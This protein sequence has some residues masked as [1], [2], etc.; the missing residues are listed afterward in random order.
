MVSIGL[1]KDANK[2]LFQHGTR[3]DHSI[4]RHRNPRVIFNHCMS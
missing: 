1:L 4:N 3:N 2:A